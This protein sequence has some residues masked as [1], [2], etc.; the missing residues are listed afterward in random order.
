MSSFEDIEDL[1]SNPFAAML[2]PGGKP[3]ELREI[4]RGYDGSLFGFDNGDW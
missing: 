2:S 3:D 4:N 1:G